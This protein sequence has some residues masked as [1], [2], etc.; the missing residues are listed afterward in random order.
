MKREP[1]IATRQSDIEK[2]YEIR[3]HVKHEMKLN[4]DVVENDAFKYVVFHKPVHF[5]DSIS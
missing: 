5:H 1:E 2:L 3:D 4:G